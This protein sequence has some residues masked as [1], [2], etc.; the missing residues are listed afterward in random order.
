MFRSR[1]SPSQNSMPRQ[2]PHKN[3]ADFKPAWNQKTWHILCFTEAKWESENSG[4]HSNELW[5]ENDN[6]QPCSTPITASQKMS[7]EGH[8]WDWSREH[9]IERLLLFFRVVISKPNHVEHPYPGYLPQQS[10]STLHHT[11]CLQSLMN[12]NHWAFVLVTIFGL[13]FSEVP[14]QNQREG[15]ERRCKTEIL[16]FLALS[17]LHIDWILPLSHQL[18]FSNS[19]IVTVLAHSGH[20]SLHVLSYT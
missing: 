4:S 16:I 3:K 15:Q 7:T 17:L 19:P 1:I 12:Y 8:V 13:P 11:M 20:S 14:V 10:K 5:R 2:F 6:S 18:S 9:K